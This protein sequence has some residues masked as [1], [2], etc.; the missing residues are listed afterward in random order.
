[1]A[2]IKY[3]KLTLEESYGEY[4]VVGCD[5]DAESV[6][7][8]YGIN[9]LPVVAIGAFAFENCSLLRSV[10]FEDI[11]EEKII[12]GFLGV[13]EIG[14]S[15]FSDC[16]ALEKINLPY[17]VGFIGRSAFADCRSLE[18][19][20]FEEMTYVSPYAFYRCKALKTVTPFDFSVSEGVFS[21]CESLE[22]FPV[23][24]GAESID[25]DAFEHCDSLTKIVIPKSVRCIEQLAFRGCKSL[26]EVKFAADDGWWVRF[27]YIDSEKHEIDVTDPK[28]NA[29]SLRGMDFDD[30]VVNWT[31]GKKE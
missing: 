11:P 29:R 10:E 20:T 3:E 21:Y 2:E 19:V 26:D 22:K 23:T 25:E 8:P 6:V 27:R 1:M 4:T 18:E 14:D 7:I 31:R 28:K 16:V 17:S 30:G 9:G 15:A 13:K 12:E 24:E 5:K